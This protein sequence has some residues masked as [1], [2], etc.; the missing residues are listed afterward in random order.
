MLLKQQLS[1]V[2]IAVCLAISGCTSEDSA[3]SLCDRQYIDHSNGT[4][5]ANDVPANFKH[6][7]LRATWQAM[8]N[9]GFVDPSIQDSLDHADLFWFKSPSGE[10][11]GCLVFKESSFINGRVTFNSEGSDKPVNI[12]LLGVPTL[13]GE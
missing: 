6:A 4:W 10:Y 9:R 11:Y 12:V 8:I 2:A 5:K 7:D 13:Y 3:K 1:G